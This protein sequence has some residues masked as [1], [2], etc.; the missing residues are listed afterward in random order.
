VRSSGFR[1]AAEHDQDFALRFGWEEGAVPLRPT[2]EER[3]IVAEKLENPGERPIEWCLV[4]QMTATTCWLADRLFA[5]WG[6]GLVYLARPGAGVPSLPAT[7]VSRMMQAAKLRAWWCDQPRLDPLRVLESAAEGCVPVQFM[8]V[9]AASELRRVLPP[10]LRAVVHEIAGD[11]SAPS[12]AHNEARST[13]AAELLASTLE[14]DLAAI[15]R[16]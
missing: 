7:G 4:D 14:R 9:H 15:P 2:D 12:L 8:P 13:L 10:S 3:D 6:N 1:F 11:G 16:S 5:S